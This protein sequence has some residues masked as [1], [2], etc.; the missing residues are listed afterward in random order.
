MEELGQDIPMTHVDEPVG[1]G[2]TPVPPP[3]PAT[4]EDPT[5]AVGLTSEQAK[6][7]ADAEKAV[8]VGA[9]KRFLHSVGVSTAGDGTS[10]LAKDSRS[11]DALLKNAATVAALVATLSRGVRAIAVPPRSTPTLTCCV[12][13]DD[14]TRWQAWWSGCRRCPQ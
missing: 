3:P 1:D 11:K 14:S 6:Q 2:G 12:T 9:V 8:K 5:G 10:L 13:L 7:L 4:A